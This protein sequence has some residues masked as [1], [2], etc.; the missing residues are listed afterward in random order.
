[1][2]A[3]LMLVVSELIR[4]LTEAKCLDAA[5]F[6][7]TLEKA[8]ELLGGSSITAGS[9]VVKQLADWMKE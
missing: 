1:M 3:G 8:S 7:V 9:R 5:A 4:A 6:R 2:N